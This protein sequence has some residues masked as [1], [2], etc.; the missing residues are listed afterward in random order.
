MTICKH[1]VPSWVT[2]SCERCEETDDV[3]TPTVRVNALA[4]KVLTV[5]TTR[6][7]GTWS[8]YCDAVPG[9]KHSEEF[10]AVLRSGD[11]LPERVARALFSE[12]DEVPYDH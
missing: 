8:A 1:G 5:A 7:E 9:R 3:W 6:I 12:F 4:C 2:P 11:K 10:D